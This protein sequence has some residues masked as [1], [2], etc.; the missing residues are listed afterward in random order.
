MIQ[1]VWLDTHLS[2]SYIDAI[3]SEVVR[4]CSPGGNT[5]CHT[6]IG[7]LAGHGDVISHSFSHKLHHSSGS[8]ASDNPGTWE[9]NTN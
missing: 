9:I 5:Q 3:Q 8:A 1:I 2:E 6:L 4:H 7:S